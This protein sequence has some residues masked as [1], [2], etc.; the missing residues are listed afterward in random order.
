VPVIDGPYAPK[1]ENSPVPIYHRLG[2]LV[3]A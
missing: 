3:G 1:H 2:W